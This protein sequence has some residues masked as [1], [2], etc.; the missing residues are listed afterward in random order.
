MKSFNFTSLHYSW[1]F[2]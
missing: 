1:L 2:C